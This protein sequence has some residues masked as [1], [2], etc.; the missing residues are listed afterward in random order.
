MRG[1]DEK[2]WMV[3][4][5]LLGAHGVRGEI[6]VHVLMEQ[7]AS[8][9]DYPTWFLGAE[10]ETSRRCA[11]LSGRANAKGLVVQLEGV[12]RREEA[13]ALS[14]TLVWM[15]RALLPE[16]EEDHYYWAD[17]IGAQVVTEAGDVLGRVSHL[18]ET[19]ANDVLSVETEGE[20]R[21]IPFTSEV[22]R[23]VDTETGVIV[24][25]LLPGM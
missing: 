14:G 21:L 25:R 13:Q 18:F 12:R 17:M 2:K 4:G 3:V 6:K 1:P 8:L 9:L 23:K 24:V 10:G 11:L 19:G 5:R 20:E 15:L 16:P 7:K 22:V